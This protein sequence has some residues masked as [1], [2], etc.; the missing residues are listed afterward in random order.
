M[1][2]NCQSCAAKYQ[3]ADEKVAGKTVRMKCRKCGATIQ[4]RPLPNGEAAHVPEGPG[5]STTMPPGSGVDD[6]MPHSQDRP[7]ISAPPPDEAPLPRAAAF[8]A[9]APPGS[10]LSAPPSW[11]P[12]SLQ[13][14]GIPRH[15]PVPRV[16][17]LPVGPSS[18]GRKP[19]APL[20]PPAGF[21]GFTPLPAPPIFGIPGPLPIPEPS[22]AVSI[23]P[24]SVSD[25]LVLTRIKQEVVPLPGLSEPTPRDSADPLAGLAENLP[26]ATP[27]PAPAPAPAPALAPAPPLGDAPAPLAP[28]GD[29][30][31]PAT[32]PEDPSTDPLTDPIDEPAA[33]PVEAAFTAPAA[34]SV[35]PAAPAA[36]EDSSLHIERLSEFPQADSF[37]DVG[38]RDRRKRQRGI[39]PLAWGLI[40]MC[41][42]LGG[43]VAWIFLAPGPA[44][45]TEPSRTAASSRVL[46]VRT[47]RPSEPASAASSDGSATALNANGASPSEPTADG[48]AGG[49]AVASPLG[50]A[51]GLTPI[52]GTGAGATG[53]EG[54]KGD[55]G[56]KG[57]AKAAAPC[58]PK[59]DPFCSAV[60]GPDGGSGT[61]VRG[62]SSAGLTQDQISATIS[63][64]SGSVQRACL[65]LVQSGAVKVNVTL[66]IGPSGN[67]SAVSTSGGGGN[68]G[69]VSCIRSKVSGW[70]FPS[71]GGT[72]Q[73]TVPFMLI[74]Q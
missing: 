7:S 49:V 16:P 43:V 33:L 2:F 48:A 28:P 40:A 4:V 14:A 26:V 69:V 44:A 15:I 50:G 11:A 70:H 66:T 55:K 32:P 30:P 38:E 17:T 68:G 42:A 51:S 45:S 52:T 72:T 29:A 47:S 19:L 58:D 22:G 5:P 39:H 27:P 3:I 37:A 46:S 53:S 8:S 35:A 63:R 36:P 10:R 59:T 67:V 6:A 54:A 21:R 13:P 65:P 20:P 9:I 1:R 31:A 64:S 18:V 61:S 71:S 34:V 60:G 41:A 57:S 73:A 23:P 12:P 62:D 24:P 56:D 74:A 25:P